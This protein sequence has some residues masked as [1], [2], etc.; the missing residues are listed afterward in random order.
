MP[1]DWKKR[2]LELPPLSLLIGLSKRLV[3][4]G[5]DGLTVYEVARFFLHGMMKGSL[6][7]RASSI[8]YNFFLATFPA[9]IFFFTIIPYIP[10]QN[11][12]EQ[13]MSL[14]KDLIPG[15]AFGLLESTI[16]DII[17]RPRGGLLSVGFIMA[18]Y[19]STN[20][21][22]S[23]IEAFNM[24]VLSVETRTAFRQ[25]M[26]AVFLV[27]LMSVFTITAIALITTGTV[28][29]DFIASRNNLVLNSYYYLLQTGK[30]VVII[31]L[32]YF[33]YSSLYYFGPAKR[34]RYRYFSAGSSLAT[35]L[36]MITSLG[37]DFYVSN[38][39]KYN[40]LYGS[41]G[42]LIILLL[43]I[44]FNSIILLVGF[45]LNASILVAGKA[46]GGLIDN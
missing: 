25:R 38:F 4:P 10:V 46:R 42:T 1:F 13:L 31:A 22:N 28:V 21:I 2:L 45:E 32:M 39:S 34:S 15:H 26:I 27:L 24:T 41:I 29:L 35:A 36:T 19:F 18:L 43:Y 9:I 3:F 33:V 7:S 16:H 20:G 12:Q 14:L 17:M 23:I 40:A 5:F 44:Y 11:F 30:W 37:F 6:T 8:A